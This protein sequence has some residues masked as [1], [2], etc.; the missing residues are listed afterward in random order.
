[1]GELVGAYNKMVDALEESTRRLAQTEREQ[2]WSEMARQIAHEIKNPLTPMR[3]SIQHLIRLKQ[4]GV[5]GWEEK[6]EDVASSLLEQI[7]IL[8]NTASEFSSFAK[9]Y[10]EETTL[11]DLAELINDQKL[12]FDTRENIRIVYDYCH[13]GCM[14]QV[15]KGQIIRVLVNL[16]SNAIQALEEKGGYIRITLREDAGF[17]IVAIDDNG[18]GV[19]PEDEHKLF[20]P[21]FT[22][23]SSGT[24]LGL[25][26]CRNI[27]EQSGGKIS[28]HRSE[29]GG[30][31]FSFS[32]PI[33]VSRIS[34]QELR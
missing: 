25:A 3:L 19:K 29:L 14:V 22:T 11:L 33:S 17:Y 12:F 31:C 13:R 15:R 28:Y 30:A 18:P 2:A 9:F 23:K 5:E 21:N 16:L 34:E 6:F 10:Y 26:I 24:G 7:D 27:I 32:L 20:K 4:R 1:M 8:S